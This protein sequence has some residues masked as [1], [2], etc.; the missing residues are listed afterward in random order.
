VHLMEE[1]SKIISKIKKEA[2]RDYGLAVFD[3]SV[4]KVKD[5]FVFTGYVLSD[6]QKTEILYAIDDL[7]GGVIDK[8][9]VLSDP[10]SS[11][12]GWC[13]VKKDYLPLKNRFVS[14]KIINEKVLKRITIDFLTKNEILRILFKREDQLLV[15]RGDLV[16]G[17]IDR[18]GVIVKKESLKKKWSEG[19][20]AKVGKTILVEG[21]SDAVVAEAKKYLGVKYVWSRKSANGVDCSALV[22]IA[23]KEAFDIILPRH[24]WD[25]KKMGILID[26]KNI[27]SGDLIF[28]IKRLNGHKHVGIVNSSGGQ[29][30]I[31]H[32]CLCEKK[33]V[34][35]NQEDVFKNYEVVEVKRIIEQKQ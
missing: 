24:S 6:N 8:V 17:W 32:A 15:Q 1:F 11:S 31:I 4:K 10:K 26:I 3:V 2:E 27:R 18:S 12:L 34:E 22:Q 29:K 16:V 30:K 7:R 23:F 21:S 28:M 19:I 25:Q 35:Q 33:V 13:A 20:H 9:K 14:R 5:N